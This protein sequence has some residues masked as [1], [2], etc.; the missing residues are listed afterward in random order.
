MMEDAN[1]SLPPTLNNHSNEDGE[2]ETEAEEDVDL[3]EAPMSNKPSRATKNLPINDI[4]VT[5][6]A[7]RDVDKL[8]EMANYVKLGGIFSVDQMRNHIAQ[9]HKNWQQQTQKSAKKKKQTTATK[10]GKNNS[11]PQPQ[12]SMVPPSS[13][14]TRT[15]LKKPIPIILAQFPDDKLY[16]WDGHHRVVAIYLGGRDELLA[17]EYMVMKCNFAFAK[18]IHLAQWFLTPFDPRTEIRLAEFGTWKQEVGELLHKQKKS[19]EEIALYIKQNKSR[20]ATSRTFHTVR[21]MLQH[22]QIK[23]LNE[24]ESENK[25]QTESETQ[26]S[27]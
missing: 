2:K 6:I 26:T 3:N 11:K 18:T 1:Q 22:M 8:M 7:V 17:E 13:P 24:Q 5:Q 27:N 12:P 9:D 19:K 20:Y 15:K 16:L 25:G 14:A 23:R 21:E 4:I 10:G